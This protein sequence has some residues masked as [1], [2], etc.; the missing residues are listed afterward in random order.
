MQIPMQY[1]FVKPYNL[2]QL[3]LKGFLLL[4][5]SLMICIQSQMMVLWQ[6]MTQVRTKAAAWG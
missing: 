2:L 6:L 4:R 1:T 3:F 5:I